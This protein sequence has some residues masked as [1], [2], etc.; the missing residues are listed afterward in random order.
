MNN[1]IEFLI[2]LGITVGFTAIAAGYYHG[3]YHKRDISFSIVLYALLVFSIVY[4]V[5]FENNIGLGIGLLGI[6]SLIRL[7]STLENLL[8]IGFIFYAI[9]I[10]LIN[11]SAASNLSLWVIILINVILTLAVCMLTTTW[12]FKTNVVKSKVT[13]DDFDMTKLGN[14]R[15]LRAYVKQKT[16]IVVK[17]V[18][19]IHID[20]LK[21]SVSVRI[22]YED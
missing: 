4:F 20:Y 18:E 7:R 6:L 11:A 5:S 12:F 1:I 21:D 3:R 16:H 22:F 17:N 10:G 19:I 15:F 8:D 13:F 9:T 2:P 14:Q